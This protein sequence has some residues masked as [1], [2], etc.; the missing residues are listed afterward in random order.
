MVCSAH[1]CKMH[2]QE[3]N[4]TLVQTAIL[5]AAMG[6]GYHC[7]GEGQPSQCVIE[8]LAAHLASYLQVAAHLQA[9]EFDS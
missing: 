9:D 5:Y 1:A 7:N 2:A 6:G 3:H 8:Q 4:L